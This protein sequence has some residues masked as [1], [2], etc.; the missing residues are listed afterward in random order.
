M[1]VAPGDGAFTL[2]HKGG[3]HEAFEDL[4]Q[5]VVDM[6]G[7]RYADSR[8]WHNWIELQMD[9]WTLQMDR[10]V[11]AYLNYCYHDMGD[12]LPA[13]EESENS[14]QCLTDTE[15]VNL[16]I[17]RLSTLYHPYL[18]V[19]LTIAYDVYLN[20]LGHVDCQ[21]KKALGCDSDNWL[22]DEPVLDFDW[23]VSIDGNNSLKR[24]DMST[25]GVSPRVDTH[26]PHSDYWLDDAYVDCFKYEVSSRSNHDNDTDNWQNPLVS[27]DPD[28]PMSF[29]CVERWHNAG[30]EQQK[31][32]FLM[33]HE[34]GIFIASCQHRFILL[35]CNMVKSGKL[36]KYPLVIISKLL[37]V[38]GK[39]GGCAYDIGCAFSATL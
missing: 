7:I 38:Y 16:F 34:S 28:I 33:F 17:S 27:T 37:S 32:M 31:R 23:L 11:N 39:N 5:Q 30:P 21:L 4:A 13:P 3:E 6:H 24:W 36:A 14:A 22:E 1:F 8:T 29:T 18:N 26:H 9:H 15:L 2:S 25:Y 12:G 20:I 35:A 10:L 19:Q